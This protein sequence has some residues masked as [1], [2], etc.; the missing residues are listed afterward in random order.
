MAGRGWSAA[1]GRPRERIAGLFASA[2]NW[3]QPV[4]WLPESRFAFLEREF[5]PKV[6]AA[7]SYD[8]AGL[9]RDGVTERGENA[10]WLRLVETAHRLKLRVYMKP[11]DGELTRLSRPE[12]I[13][14]WARA[15]FAVAP[16]RRA[17]AVRLPGEAVLVPWTTANLCLA[18]RFFTPELLKL[19]RLDWRAARRRIVSSVADR[20]SRIIDAIR[21]HA[22]TITIDLECCDTPVLETL[23]QRHENLGVMYMCYGQFPRAAEYLE[24][25]QCVASRQLRA[26]RV[27]L[28]TDCYYTRSITGLG[29][30]RGKPYAELYSPEDLRLMADKHRHLNSLAADA[31]WIWGLNITHTEAKFEAVSNAYAR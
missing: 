17:D 12:D 25:Y 23:L 5:L 18:P 6:A 19:H 7:G 2:E 29:Q 10:A 20:F 13:E 4:S 24:L 9:S 27:V 28:E 16:D 8:A 1:R 14:A 11:G 31:V 30:L 3:T 21:R 15:C 22:P 26:A